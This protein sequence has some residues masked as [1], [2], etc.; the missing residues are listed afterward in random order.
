MQFD[1]RISFNRFDRIILLVLV[2]LGLAVGLLALVYSLRGAAIVR[3]YPV[4]GGEVGA[5][6]R[7]GIEFAQEMQPDLT[8]AAFRI[9]PALAGELHWD[10]LILW[11]VPRQAYEPAVVYTAHLGTGAISRDGR[12]VRNEVTWQFKIRQVGIVFLM[13]SGTDAGDIWRKPAAGGEGQPITKT[14][15][16][17][18]GFSVSPDGEWIAYSANNP[19]G[20]A[21]LWLI[22]RSGDAIRE[23]V[24]CGRAL[25]SQPAWSIDGQRIAY[26]R[27]SLEDG[28]ENDNGQSHVWTVEVGSGKAAPLYP[29][30]PVT[31][32]E[33]AWSPDG[34]R[35]SFYD[36][37][38]GG[39]RLVDLK[40]S[41][42]SIV[43]TTQEQVGSW[44][45]DGKILLYAYP[46]TINQ[47]L[48]VSVFQADVASGETKPALGPESVGQNDYGLPAWSPDG[49]WVVVG[50]RL[51]GTSESKQLLV[52]HL[53]GSSAQEITQT[54]AYTYAA[55]HWDPYGKAIVFQRFPQNESGGV[56]E[57]GVWQRNSGQMTI[58]A[59]GAVM[60]D[61][62]P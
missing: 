52:S 60:P 17:V 14:A 37:D 55:Y 48:S 40:T 32:T 28:T 4:S 19:E 13:L 25:C 11:F 49:A 18:T 10:G 44:S 58:L 29:Q 27:I 56:P 51:A 50:M 21:D 41:Q 62:L 8:R 3:T 38:A 43:P 7:V 22:S 35:L 16:R 23:L 53:D 30:D 59:Q 1:K 33:P 36:Q 31:G 15:G 42:E 47:I 57:V 26:S 46:Q 5:R 2:I 20:G 12:R 9:E 45:P 34:A 61:W 39:I 6:A 24:T 54:P